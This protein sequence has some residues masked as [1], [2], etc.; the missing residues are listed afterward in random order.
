[1]I[2]FRTEF[3]MLGLPAGKYALFGS[4]QL[5][6]KNLRP[7]NDLDIIVKLELWDDLLKRFPQH[8]RYNPQRIHIGNIELFHDWMNLTSKIDEMI[9]NAEIIECLP[10]VRIEYLL[11]WKRHMKRPK[12]IV[13]IEMIEEYLR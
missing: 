13:D 1:M 10:H 11:E 5:A 8:V 2:P 3:E 7:A 4:A 6:A 12:D 9:D